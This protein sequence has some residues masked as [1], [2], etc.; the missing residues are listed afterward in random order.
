MTP[1]ALVA[2][3]GWLAIIY[4][5]LCLFA[6]VHA[7]VVTSHLY[8]RFPWREAS[9]MLALVARSG[10]HYYLWWPAVPA[11]L[12][13]AFS[14]AG[15]EYPAVFTIS[16]FLCWTHMVL[17]QALPASVLL[18]GTSRPRTLALRHALERR[19]YPYRVAVLLEP[20]TSMST[21]DNLF[22]RNLFE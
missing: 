19:L 11:I 18:L 12:L 21:A 3:F 15:V 7:W 13:L 8:L 4:A 5:T 9:A 16:L 1:T 2:A 17:Y 6:D 20:A 10:N 14:A 22:K